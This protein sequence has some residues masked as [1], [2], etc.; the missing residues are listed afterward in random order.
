[1]HADGSTEQLDIDRSAA[2]ASYAEALGAARDAG[3]KLAPEPIRL[4][5]QD[6]LVQIVKESQKQ[7][8]E[9]KGGEADEGD[10]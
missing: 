2:S 4:T 8:L 3:F 5:P 7:A 6:K 1:V 10:A 9:G